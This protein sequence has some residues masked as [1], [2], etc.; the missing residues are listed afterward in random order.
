MELPS[1]IL[2]QITFKTRLKIEEHILI[3]VDKST[4]EEQLS[5]TLQTE[6]KQF[7]IAFTFF[8]GI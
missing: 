7:K 2:E 8:N 5:Q 1:K 4:H 6:K 3:V